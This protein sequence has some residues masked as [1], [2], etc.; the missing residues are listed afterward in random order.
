MQKEPCQH[1]I[2]FAN[3][4]K[5]WIKGNG[6]TTDIDQISSVLPIAERG[7]K[8]LQETSN[9]NSNVTDNVIVSS[10]KSLWRNEDSEMLSAYGLDQNHVQIIKECF[11][12]FKRTHAA[13]RLHEKLRNNERVLVIAQ[14]N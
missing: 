12:R 6:R 3:Y 11:E 8:I 14:R 7:V 2:A 10:G 13:H 4:L 5:I 1:Y 9:L